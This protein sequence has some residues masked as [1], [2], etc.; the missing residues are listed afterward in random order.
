MRDKRFTGAEIDARIRLSERAIEYARAA[1][2][3][4]V[5]HPSQIL[6]LKICDPAMGSGAFLVETCRQLG[7]E[8]IKSWYVHCK[9]GPGVGDQGSEES[10]KVSGVGGQV[11]EVSQSALRS[12][13]TRSPTP[14]TRSRRRRRLRWPDEF[15]DEV[16][17]RLLELNEQRHREE[18]LT[19]KAVAVSGVGG[20]GSGEEDQEEGVGDQGS[21][22]VGKKAKK[23][24]KSKKAPASGQQE[25][26]F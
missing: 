2:E 10:E 15:R 16:L 19:G 9:K 5:P 3:V 23:P 25:M 11:S 14:E 24:R 12:P 8:L 4:G 20:Q 6:E 7:D 26:E 22:V 18:L 21:G 13:E 1:R 17:A